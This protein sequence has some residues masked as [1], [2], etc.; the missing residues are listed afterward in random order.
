MSPPLMKTPVARKYESRVE[1]SVHGG[2]M[3]SRRGII[4]GRQHD[5][6]FEP[7][8]DAYNGGRY[9]DVGVEKY[10][11]LPTADVPG[12]GDDIHFFRHDISKFL[13][14]FIR[15][16]GDEVGKY[17]ANNVWIM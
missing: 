2:Q 11:P 14:F 3:F 16:F 7:G 17:L 4:I 6:L 15:P 8:N 1:V 10:N 5:F 12:V 13:E 9:N